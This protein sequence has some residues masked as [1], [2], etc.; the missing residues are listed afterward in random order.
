[1]KGFGKKS[2]DHLLPRL[3]QALIQ[4][5]PALISSSE[6]EINIYVGLTEMQRKWYRSVLERL[7][8]LLMVSAYVVFALLFFYNI[9]IGLTGKKEG[10]TRLMNIIVQVTF[11][12]ISLLACKVACHL[13]IFDGAVRCVFPVS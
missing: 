4:I 13:Y 7:S 6:K 11:I 3:P 5:S 9:R 10:K 8:T 1:M 12:L 2:A